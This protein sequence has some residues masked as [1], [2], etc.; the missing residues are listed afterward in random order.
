MGKFPF[1]YR[2]FK[3]CSS[4]GK[5]V[6]GKSAFINPLDYKYAFL[7][8]YYYKSFEEYCLKFKRGWLDPT[9]QTIWI[10]NLLKDNRHSKEKL[11]IIKKILNL[12]I[13]N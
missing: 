9:N 13:V 11:K 6:S 4:S 8:H 5:N 1:I 10:N 12:T 3:S 7:K 2:F